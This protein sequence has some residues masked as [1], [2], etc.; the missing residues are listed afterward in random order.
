M[1]A[2]KSDLAVRTATGGGAQPEVKLEPTAGRL[3]G[4]SEPA[5]PALADLPGAGVVAGSA[6]KVRQTPPAVRRK[7]DKKGDI[8]L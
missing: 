5:K 7:E 1:S 2:S 3:L 6:S 4:T 8:Q